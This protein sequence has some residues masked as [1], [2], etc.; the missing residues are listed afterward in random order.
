MRER[1]T[2]AAYAAQT[3]RSWNVPQASVSLW[4]RP[5]IPRGQ[6]DEWGTGAV[7]IGRR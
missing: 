3:G 7:S 5:Q 1:S 4:D 2:S 6:P